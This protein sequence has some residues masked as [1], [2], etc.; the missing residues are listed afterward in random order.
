MV[1]DLAEETELRMENSEDVSQNC[2]CPKKHKE[3]FVFLSLM[4][5]AGQR[6]G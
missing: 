4:W 2:S 1:L 3:L 6:R 5:T